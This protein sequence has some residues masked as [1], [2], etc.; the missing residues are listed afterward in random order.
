[1]QFVKTYKDLIA[2]VYRGVKGF[3]CIATAL[4][5]LGCGQGEV[6]EPIVDSRGYIADSELEKQLV[7]GMSSKEDVRALFGSP[8]TISTFGD[9]SWYYIHATRERL[10]FFKPEI[11]DQQV[12]R[13]Y[14]DVNGYYS[15]LERYNQQDAETVQIVEE[16]TPTAGQGLGFFE[17]ILGNLGRFNRPPGQ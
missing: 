15:R 17:Q 8:S 7:V 5:L 10:A 6:I 16:T 13:I 4:L 3:L 1:M 9:E 11:T 14:F 2:H 12:T